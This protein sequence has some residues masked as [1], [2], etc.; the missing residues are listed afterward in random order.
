MMLQPLFV[1][2]CKPRL[3]YFV[4]KNNSIFFYKFEV[5]S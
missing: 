4:S 2:T 1:C 3:E 5:V